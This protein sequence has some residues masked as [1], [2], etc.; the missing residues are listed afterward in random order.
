M[1]T[2][3]VRARKRDAFIP[4]KACCL[5]GGGHRFIRS[6]AADKI[7]GSGKSESGGEN[8]YLRFTPDAL[9]LFVD[10]YSE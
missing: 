9:E 3:A 5:A 7:I 4:A 2:G 8:S 6:E 10:W 1:G